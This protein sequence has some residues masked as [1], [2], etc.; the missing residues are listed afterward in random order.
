LRD[1][2][3]FAWDVD[4]T[5]LHGKMDHDLYI[6]FPN[7][8]SKPGM[9]GK[10]N[11]ALYGLPEAAWVWCEDFKDK[12]RTLGYEPLESDP[13]FSCGNLPKALLLLTPMWTTGLDMFKRGGG[14]GPEAWDSE[15]L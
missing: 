15:L 11:K 10:L 13:V 5:Y 6:D 9:V 2:R 4:S 14:V 1:L 7:G 8:Y 3:I 12:L